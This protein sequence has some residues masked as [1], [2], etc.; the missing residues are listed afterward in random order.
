VIP[1]QANSPVVEQFWKS[2]RLPMEE[3]G[4]IFLEMEEIFFQPKG[5]G[6]FFM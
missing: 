2:I 6:G 1:N 4:N 5:M 3:L